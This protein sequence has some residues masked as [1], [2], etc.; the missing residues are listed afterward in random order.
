MKAFV[1]A[2]DC[3]A[4]AVISNMADCA[5]STV[6]GRKVV[7]GAI[8]GVDTAVVVA[9]VGKANAAAGAQLALSSLGADVLLNVGVAGGLVPGMKVGEV[10][11]IDRAVQFDF[12][13]SKINGTPIGTPIIIAPA[14][15]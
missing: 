7:R 3:E 2:M 10:Y 12:D 9:G 5:A 15:T 4:D 11:R 1:V 13:L 14:V 6:F 8:D